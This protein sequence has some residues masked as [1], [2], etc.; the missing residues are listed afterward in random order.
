[1]FFWQFLQTKLRL[2]ITQTTERDVTVVFTMHEASFTLVNFATIGLLFQF[3]QSLQIIV[4]E[5]TRTPAVK[6]GGSIPICFLKCIQLARKCETIGNQSHP[7]ASASPRC[8]IKLKVIVMFNI[9]F[10]Y[11]LVVMFVSFCFEILSLH[12]TSSY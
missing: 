10:V 1:M 12:I 11:L 9:A 8:L 5:Y 6:V 3:P 2:S 7:R 4:R